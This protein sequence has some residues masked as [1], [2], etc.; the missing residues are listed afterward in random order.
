MKIKTQCQATPFRLL[1]ITL[2]A[3][4]QCSNN[5]R[6]LSLAEKKGSDRKFWKLSTIIMDKK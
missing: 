1:D 3:L 2:H 4:L 6:F 5:Q